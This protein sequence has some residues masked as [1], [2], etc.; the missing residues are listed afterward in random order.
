MQ[1]RGERFAI[2]AVEVMPKTANGFLVENCPEGVILVTD[3]ENFKISY[4]A[5][6]STMIALHPFSHRQ[7]DFQKVFADQRIGQ[8][9]RD[10]YNYSDWVKKIKYKAR[11]IETTAQ[12]ITDDAKQ[13]D[14]HIR[15]NLQELQAKIHD[16]VTQ[17]EKLEPAVHS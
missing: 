12:G 4:A 16:A 3:R 11:R 5:L 10:A 8:L 14:G 13:L 1:L 15:Q 17:F 6:K 9:I 7:I 2:L